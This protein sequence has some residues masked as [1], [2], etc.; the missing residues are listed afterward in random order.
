MVSNTEM[1]TVFVRLLDEGTDV[2]RPVQAERIRPGIFR[3]FEPVD[4]DPEY[5]TWE[6]MPGSLVRCEIRHINNGAIFVAV[7]MVRK[8]GA[9]WTMDVPAGIASPKKAEIKFK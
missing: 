2:M 5:E 8:T 4:Y 7:A 9:K 6:F 1:E 3:L